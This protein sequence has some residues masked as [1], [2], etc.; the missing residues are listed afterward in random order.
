MKPKS[1]AAIATER[2]RLGLGR[3]DLKKQ[4]QGSR[5]PHLVHHRL[6][7]RTSRFQ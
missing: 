7:V 5:C 4:K 3:A 2:S 6:K 1:L